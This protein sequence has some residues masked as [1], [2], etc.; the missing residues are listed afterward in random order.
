MKN[1]PLLILDFILDQE[2]DIIILTE[3][4]LK[5]DDHL[6]IIGHATPEG[7]SFVNV[8][9]NTGNGGGIALI[10]KCNIKINL[11]K[12]ETFKTFEH[13]ACV[14]T[15]NHASIC[16]VAIYRPP[17]NAVNGFTTSE[18]FTEFTQAANDF[19][20][21]NNQL[22]ITG[23]FNIHLDKQSLPDTIKLNKIIDECG[24]S[25]ISSTKPTHIKG[26]C[27]DAVISRRDSI[28]VNDIRTFYAGFSD[29]YAILFKIK[30]NKPVPVRK[31][32]TYR[33]IRAINMVQLK[34]DVK[35]MELESTSYSADEYCDSYNGQ[36][37]RILNKHAPEITKSFIIRPN[38]QWYNSNIRNAKVVKRRL[39]RKWRKSG[40]M[41]DLEKYRRQCKYINYLLR[42]A[43]T[44]FFSNKVIACKNDTRKLYSTCKN[45]LNWKNDLVLPSHNPTSL[46]DDFN[47]FFIDK[48]IKIRN[49]F[50]S[51]SQPITSIVDDVINADINKL[52]SF[53]PTTVEEIK[54]LLSKSSP[55]SCLLDPMPTK[56]VKE[57][58]DEIAP[59]ITSIVN[60]SINT[61][62]MPCEWKKALVIPLLKKVSADPES[63][64][65]YR[66]V[67]NLAF[68]SKNH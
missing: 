29:H 57:C 2:L 4:W 12:N 49:D 30:D 7:Y 62:V 33:N 37:N 58:I 65:N 13:L 52:S 26:H 47:D 11:I 31:T 66:P 27:L 9:R 3:T 39:E 59:V 20:L 21:R 34:E 42:E 23:D 44:E 54:K 36:L 24:M 5:S 28:T 55:A 14:A 18:F 40:S 35:S 53:R 10:H 43:K 68:V 45:I 63:Y 64:K 8:P 67:S 25:I 50:T 16:F 46:P 19:S 22:V 61:C 41:L 56:L 32:I 48:I 6:D 15:F 60:C 38:T 17:P 1:K 51:N